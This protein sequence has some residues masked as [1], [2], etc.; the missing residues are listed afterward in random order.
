MPLLSDSP[1]DVG[2]AVQYK[3][4]GPDEYIILK[5]V[6]TGQTLDTARE[7][8]AKNGKFDMSEFNYSLFTSSVKDYLILNGDGS[9]WMLT[10]DNLASVPQAFT[11]WLTEQI[12]ACD[13]SITKGST[14]TIKGIE[15]PFRPTT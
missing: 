5:S 10:N 6:L 14:V 11:Q 12:N 7:A 4:F 2:I 15:V 13:G 9:P 1:N 3:T 8:A